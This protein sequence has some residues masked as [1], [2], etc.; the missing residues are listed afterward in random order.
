MGTGPHCQV[1]ESV[2]AVIYVRCTLFLV[3]MLSSKAADLVFEAPQHQGLSGEGCSRSLHGREE[4]PDCV[5]QLAGLNQ[6]GKLGGAV[7]GQPAC[8]HRLGIALIH[9]ADRVKVLTSCAV[10]F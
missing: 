8:N 10:T 7:E 6:L 2:L 5:S 9:P 1:P 3:S 4:L